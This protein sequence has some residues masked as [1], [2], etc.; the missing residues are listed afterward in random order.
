MN[1]QVD[2]VKD[3]MKEYVKSFFHESHDNII[4]VAKKLY[5]V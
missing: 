3:T 4:K 2:K 1:E 5:Y